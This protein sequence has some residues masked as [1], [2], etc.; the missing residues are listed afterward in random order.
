MNH[1]WEPADVLGECP[2]L[3]SPGLH[4]WQF[5]HCLRP[6]GRYFDYCSLC[7]LHSI[8][9]YKERELWVT[10]LDKRRAAARTRRAGGRK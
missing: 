6:S 7:N 5:D 9:T 2:A 1:E 4:Q 10:D 3:A 8:F